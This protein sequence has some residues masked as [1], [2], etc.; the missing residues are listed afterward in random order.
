ML[1][2]ATLANAQWCWNPAKW[3][4][5]WQ[6]GTHLR[7]LS[8]S[9]PMNINITAFRWFSKIV[10]PCASASEGLNKHKTLQRICHAYWIFDGANTTVIH[11][12]LLEERPW[13]SY[14]SDDGVSGI[15]G[16]S[17]C[18]HVARGTYQ[19]PPCHTC[20]DW[21]TRGIGCYTMISLR[22]TCEDYSDAISALTSPI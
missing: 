11:W 3:L 22:N 8:E 13:S 19:I 20:R 15:G 6:M 5:P 12:S 2:V 9:Y 10:V 17:H 18:S 14:W 16:S 21:F 4:K 7:V 1:L